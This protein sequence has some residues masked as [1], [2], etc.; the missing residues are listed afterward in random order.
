M[1]EQNYRFPL[2][3]QGSP[4][5]Y[6][7]L[8]SIANMVY[9]AVGRSESTEEEPFIGAS[10]IGPVEPVIRMEAPQ[11]YSLLDVDESRVPPDLESYGCPSTKTCDFSSAK[12]PAENRF[13]PHLY[14]EPISEPLGAVC[15]M[16]YDSCSGSILQPPSK[17][18][19]ADEPTIVPDKP[20]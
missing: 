18:E 6:D 16:T 1:A 9:H 12:A 14:M 2:D 15:N 3:T 20:R 8:G 4:A 7:G 10:Y 13:Q 11:T 17:T 19:V 5:L